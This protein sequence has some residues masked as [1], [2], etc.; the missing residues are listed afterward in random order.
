MNVAL[1]R[2][3]SHLTN[4]QVFLLPKS[5]N[6]NSKD[7]LIS[8]IHHAGLDSGGV[9]SFRI[10]STDLLLAVAFQLFNNGNR[11]GAAFVPVG[12]PTDRNLLAYLT[13]NNQWKTSPD[14][15]FGQVTVT[16]CL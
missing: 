9:M 15:K 2:P 5:I 14:Q 4:G 3:S 7:V 11:F 1:T 8:I 10:G 13:S 16:F 12:V 6:K